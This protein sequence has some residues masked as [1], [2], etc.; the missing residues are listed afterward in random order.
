MNH[1]V[2]LVQI[3]GIVLGFALSLFLAYRYITTKRACLLPFAVSVL[4]HIIRTGIFT[5]TN[6]NRLTS[7][8][9]SPRNF[10][11][12]NESGFIHLSFVLLSAYFLVIG[13]FRM[14][15]WKKLLPLSLVWWAYSSIHL[16]VS[17]RLI[18]KLDFPPVIGSLLSEESIYYLP[19]GIAKTIVAAACLVIVFSKADTENSRPK[20]IRFGCAAIAISQVFDML[21]RVI[22]VS[23]PDLLAFFYVLMYAGIVLIML[24]IRKESTVVFSEDRRVSMEDDLTRRFSLNETER[25][26]LEAILAG[27]SNK[28]IAYNE[29]TSLSAI[30]HRIFALYKKLGVSSRYELL[31]GNR[32]K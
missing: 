23:R 2:F 14:R 7:L 27:S 30:K 11:S 31:A 12:T 20:F 9:I 28:E 32:D 19:F 5:F 6:Y 18:L 16:F 25:R 22:E 13:L 10:E 15:N 24:G 29:K 21:V 3:S 26:I 17:A 8:G 1:L 4:A